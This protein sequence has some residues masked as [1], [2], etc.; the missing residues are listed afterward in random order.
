M[1]NAV[2]AVLLICISALSSAEQNVLS[3]CL[4]QLGS[5]A[6]NY[7]SITDLDNDLS[8]R[9]RTNSAMSAVSSQFRKNSAGSVIVPM[10]E[11]EYNLNKALQLSNFTSFQDQ[12]FKSLFE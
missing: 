6:P 2:R 3:S 1:L 9:S 5:E 12:L 10:H 8:P 11:P 7:G 4:L